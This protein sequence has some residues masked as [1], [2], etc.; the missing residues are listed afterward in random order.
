MDG[1]DLTKVSIESLRR[2]MGVMTQD[3]FIFHG[4]VRD[5]ILYGKLDATDEEMI[6]AA[7]AV[8]AHDFIMKL[9]DAYETRVGAG[10][11]TFPAASARE[12]R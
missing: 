6:A 5:N 12:Y 11:T 7:K 9:P 8:N 3:N 4:T 2:Q 10:A 1:Y